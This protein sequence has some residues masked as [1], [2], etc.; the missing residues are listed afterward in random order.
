[1]NVDSFSPFV[2][3]N[4][5]QAKDIQA[6]LE[7]ELL[8]D[9]SRNSF[10]QYLDEN[11]E[12]EGGVLLNST[13]KNDISKAPEQFL[14]ENV[15]MGTVSNFLGGIAKNEISAPEM[16]LSIVSGIAARNVGQNMVQLQETAAP[17]ETLIKKNEYQEKSIANKFVPKVEVAP[18]FYKIVRNEDEKVSDVYIRGGKGMLSS[19]LLEIKNQMTKLIGAVRHFFYNGAQ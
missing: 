2:F 9:A 11:K 4:G 16:S 1:M 5:L 3:Q 12:T 19:Q 7:V 13:R 14:V 15:G 8:S 6:S 10:E 18:S 17:R